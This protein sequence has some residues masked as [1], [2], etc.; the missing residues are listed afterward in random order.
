MRTAW[1]RCITSGLQQWAAASRLTAASLCSPVLPTALCCPPPRPP[2]SPPTCCRVVLPC[3]P[4][5]TKE[6]VAPS[7]PSARARQSQPRRARANIISFLLAMAAW[8]IAVPAGAG[9]A[10]GWGGS[11]VAQ[12]ATGAGPACWEADHVMQA[13]P[14]LASKCQP[15]HYPRH[16]QTTAQTTSANSCSPPTE[17]LQLTSVPSSTSFRA[18]DLSPQP[19][20]AT[21]NA[22]QGKE[23]GVWM[24]WQQ[25]CQGS[26]S[27]GGFSSSESST[28][29]MQT[30]AAASL[31]APLS[32]TGQHNRCA[33]RWSAVRPSLSTRC[34]SAPRSTSRSTTCTGGLHVPVSHGLN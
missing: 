3:W 24:P 9:K 4:H 31:A 23:G 2:C 27:S 29:Q 21:H 11:R 34:R 7:M 19:A 8:C 6:A 28:L 15:R 12:G 13:A 30:G 20:A 22:M 26:A 14:K 33:P 1:Q 10:I 32:D 17:S 16:S 18:I 25:S 5:S